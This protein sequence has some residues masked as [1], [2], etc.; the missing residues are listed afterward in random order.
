MLSSQVN[1]I[2]SPNANMPWNPGKNNVT[3]R[4]E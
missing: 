4:D 2:V 3:D 1:Y